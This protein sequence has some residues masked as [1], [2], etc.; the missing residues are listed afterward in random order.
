MN[1]SEE[2]NRKKETLKEKL[3]RTLD[4]CPDVFG[5]ESY[6]EIRGRGSMTVSGCRRILQ[7]T[8]KQICLSLERGRLSVEGENLI[9]TSYFSGSVGIDGH[10][11]GV[12][13]EEE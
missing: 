7:Y 11:I 3:C 4:L 10:L 2:K 5:K 6:V 12:R 13:F 9:C 1:G 8:P